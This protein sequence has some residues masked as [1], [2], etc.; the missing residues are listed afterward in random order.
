MKEYLAHSKGAQSYS[1]HVDET[2][3][4]A[5]EYADGMAGYMRDDRE[6]FRSVLKAAA[7]YHDLGK[8]DPENQ[9]VLSG[10]DSNKSLP[11]NHWD[12]GVAFLLEEEH[13][14]LLSAIAVMSHHS[15]L[16][17]F[18]Y[19]SNHEKK[20]NEFRSIDIKEHVD[21]SLKELSNIHAQLVKITPEFTNKT[22]SGDLS[23][24]LR[25]LLS[26]LADGDRTDTERNNVKHPKAEP[27]AGLRPNER[28]ACLDR[29][30]DTLSKSNDERDRLRNEMYLSCKNTEI[31]E[32]IA[33]CD[34]P[35]GSGKTTAVMAHLLSEAKRRKLR[36]IFV[37]LPD[38]NIIRQSVEIYR[39]ALVL[40]GE[41]PD[42]V[43]AEIYHRADFESNYM[44]NLTPPWSAPII[45]TTAAAFFETLAEHLPNPLR[46]M[47]ELP[48]SAI[49]LDEAHTMLP[50]KLLPLAWQWINIL[51]DEWS[52]YW[53]LA[54]GS[55]NRFWEISEISKKKR[56]V[57]EITPA[58]LRGELSVFETNR[59]IYENRL[60]AQT[61]DEL[62]DW[63]ASFPGPRLLIFNTVQ[64][65]AVAASRFADK[66][67]RGSVEHLSTSLTANDRAKTLKRVKSR[68][69][70]KNDRDWT[71]V[72]TSCVEVGIDFSFHTGFR[73]LA[74]LISLLQTAGRI[75]RRGSVLNAQIWTFTLTEGGLVTSNPGIKNAASVL[76]DIFRRGVPIEPKLTTL[77]IEEEIKLYGLED[78]IKQYDKRQERPL[79]HEQLIESEKDLN[80]PSIAKNFKVIDGSTKIAVISQDIA[81]RINTNKTDWREIQLN[82]V[83]VL[84][85]ELKELSLPQIKEG[86][87]YWTLPYDNFLGHMARII[88]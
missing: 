27:H 78:K 36:R 64:T 72:A 49:F 9:A 25:I 58:K 50:V 39:K 24:F 85:D 3:R 61:V 59:I 5:L 22:L 76:R 57:P 71:L 41:K 7:V 46:R 88:K 34:S 38:T 51:A 20:E 63:T 65:A 29:Y 6:L 84:E 32:N 87:Y 1:D 43:I 45:V 26:C 33:S 42:D 77:A 82:S 40:P 73:E 86:I 18:I 21:S 70:Y 14:S 19:E 30:I 28:L 8:L 62:I 80:F 69:K 47:H 60:S 44:P 48:G 79:N 31:S 83:Q 37:V 56:R 10:K 68:L 17:N 35:A 55:L 53:V 11:I 54:S 75:N 81:D 12:A 16:P 13:K 74:S 23:V 66:F 2:V 4:L 67:G 52:C 15:G